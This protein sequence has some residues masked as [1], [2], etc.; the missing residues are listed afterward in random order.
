M[1]SFRRIIPS[2]ARRQTLRRSCTAAL[3]LSISIASAAFLGIIGISDLSDALAF[4]GRFTGIL[5][6]I[7]SMLA[8]VGAFTFLD[9]WFYHRYQFSG[10][11]AVV[12]IG[13]AF[14]T[15]LMLV[16]ITVRDWEWRWTSFCCGALAVGSAWALYVT[17]RSGVDISVPRTVGATVIVSAILAA[18][19]FGYSHV[20]VPYMRP[21]YV[22]MKVVLGE[23]AL[24]NNSSM[25]SVPATI[26]MSNPTNAGMYVLENE[27]TT[28]GARESVKEV[29]RSDLPRNSQD[30]K[31]VSPFVDE[32]VEFIQKAEFHPGEGAF[33][34]PGEE[35][36]T[37]QNIEFPVQK[38]YQ[39]LLFRTDAV[40]ARMDR[41]RIKRMDKKA[42]WEH[43]RERAC[44]RMVD[45]DGRP[46]DCIKTT[47]T[48]IEGNRITQIVRNPRTITVWRYVRSESPPD[49][50]LSR[51]GK[52]FKIK[53][54][55]ERYG[56][57]TR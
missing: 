44:P 25:I 31:D 37:T 13:A 24:E 40:V 46:P 53:S 35:I 19:N 1:D 8:F 4:V 39:N 43:P 42:S 20:Y 12:G 11:I 3:V 7:S 41:V 52:E 18:V 49:A 22:V 50:A 2:T 17:Y 57:A 30:A 47:F 34:F 5:L 45:V 28:L 23:P 14:I 16:I 15:N 56:D 48:I 38:K 10:F 55:S 32:D 9:H 54:E 21:R 27:Y 51:K 6:I 33:L 29:G 26:T 36:S